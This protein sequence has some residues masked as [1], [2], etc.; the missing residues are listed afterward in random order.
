MLNALLLIL[1]G[2]TG[3][4][5]VS[6]Q[7]ECQEVWGPD[8]PAYYQ[9][10]LVTTRKVPGAGNAVGITSVSYQATPFGIAI[11]P[12]GSYVYDL[13]V[14]IDRLA[15]ARKGAYVAWVST[16]EPSRSHQNQ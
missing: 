3:F 2:A 4:S 11:A 16:P 8:P 14:K 15:P 5:V 1:M 6:A 12:D 13:H 7:V 10:D 9:I